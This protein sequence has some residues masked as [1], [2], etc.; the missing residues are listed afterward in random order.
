MGR[1]ARA[2]ASHD[3]RR[4]G[5]AWLMETWAY[6][7]ELGRPLPTLPLWLAENLAIPVDLEQSY[8]ETCG[9]LRIP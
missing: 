6:P 4:N 7:L 5:D 1:F 8:E 3:R 2:V 9:I